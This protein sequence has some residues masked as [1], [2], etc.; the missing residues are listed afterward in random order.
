LT[1]E[2]WSRAVF[3]RK[4][5]KNDLVGA[6]VGNPVASLLCHGL[7]VSRETLNTSQHSSI[8]TRLAAAP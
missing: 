7:A 6:I 2:I 1:A 3:H 8:L 4:V 5:G